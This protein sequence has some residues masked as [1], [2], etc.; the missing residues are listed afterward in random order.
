[1]TSQERPFVGP[2]PGDYLGLGTLRP[3][4]RG[5]KKPVLPP[6]P[7]RGKKLS[8]QRWG[9]AGV[10]LGLHGILLVL[11]MV[12][13]MPEVAPLEVKHREIIPIEVAFVPKPANVVAA[14]APR[15]IERRPVPRPRPAAPE[16]PAVKPQPARATAPRPLPPQ[17]AVR[18]AVPAPRPAV[19]AFTPPKAPD[20]RLLLQ[21]RINQGRAQEEQRA[22]QLAGRLQAGEVAGAPSP[23]GDPLR[24]VSIDMGDPTGGLGG[25]GILRRIDPR[26]PERMQR[27]YGVG[28]VLVRVHVAPDGTVSRATVERSSGYLDI[29]NAVK[30]A[31]VRWRFSPLPEGDLGVQTGVIPF[32]F[33]IR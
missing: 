27:E 16:R 6:P 13:P 26:Y 33:E 18:A 23:A 28:V 12:V 2:D 19:R 25:R 5:K 17:P 1:M 29:D 15:A 9:S 31:V 4:P 22:S 32:H 21:A 3:D 30:G 10:S 7:A 20:P 14:V 24:R 8:R 11:M